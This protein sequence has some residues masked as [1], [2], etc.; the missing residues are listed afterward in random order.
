MLKQMLVGLRTF[1]ILTMQ[2]MLLIIYIGIRFDN[3]KGG[4]IFL[5]V[6]Y[7]SILIYLFVD[8]NLHALPY[9]KSPEGMNLIFLKRMILPVLVMV[10]YKFTY[11]LIIFMIGFAIIELLFLIKAQSK[12]K[13]YVYCI[14][15]LCCYSTIGIFIILEL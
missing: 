12:I 13:S 6:I 8:C 1:L 2:E 15:E 4:D 3:L 14:L 10:P 9:F 11:N 7:L 5:I